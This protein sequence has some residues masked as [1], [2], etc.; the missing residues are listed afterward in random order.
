MNITLMG[1]AGS[2]KS[3]VGKELAK[4]L[5]YSFVDVDEL[6]IAKYKKTLNEIIDAFGE[7]ELLRAEGKEVLELGDTDKSV[8]APGGSVIYLD[9]AMGFL[10]KV[11]KI[12]FL[13]VP[14]EVVNKRDPNARGIIGLRTKTLEEIY[15]ERAPLLKKYADLTIPYQ[16]NRTAQDI[17]HE[18]KTRCL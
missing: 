15:N 14:F 16:K 1:M 11:S 7:D 3:T 6:V 9:D 18:I 2:G 12:V 4:E 17:A 13:D 10:K 8:I 5:G